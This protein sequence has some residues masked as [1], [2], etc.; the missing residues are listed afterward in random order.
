MALRFGNG[1]FEPIWNRRYV[2]ITEAETVG[3]EQRGGWLIRWV[4]R[5]S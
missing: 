5:H 2:Q 3:V 4:E 1:I